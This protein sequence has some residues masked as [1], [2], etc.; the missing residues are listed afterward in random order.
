M[1]LVVPVESQPIAYIKAAEGASC[2]IV[3]MVS[4]S[5]AAR[6]MLAGFMVAETSSKLPAPWL[7]SPM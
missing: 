7:N 4:R 6:E 5:E 3:L 2:C 1:L